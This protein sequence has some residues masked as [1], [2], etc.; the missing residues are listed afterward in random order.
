MPT[1]SSTDAPRETTGPA[2]RVRLVLAG[3]GHAQLSV[4][5]A[6]A[7]R[8]RADLDATLITPSPTAIYSGMVPG[9]MAGEH[10]LRAVQIDL[11]RLAERAGV[12]LIVD[13]VTALDANERVLCTAAGRR[14]AY[15][16]LSLDVGGAPEVRDF[17]PLGDRAMAVRPLERFVDQWH[18]FVT[19][20]S[21]RPKTD[22]VVVGGGAAGVELALAA[23]RALQARRTHATV[24]LVAAPDS[25][26]RGLARGAARRVDR[27]LERRG[28]LV[29]RG[30]ARGE[31]AAVRLDSG[32][33]IPADGV[34]IATG[35]VPPAWLNESGLELAATGGVAVGATQR[36]RSHANVFAA[37]D[38]C[39]RIDRPLARSGVHAVKA[40][41]VLARNLMAWPGE[42]RGAVYQPNRR[43]LM[44]LSTGGEQAI[45]SWGALSAEGRW[46]WRLKRTIDRRFIQQHSAFAADPRTP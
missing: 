43:T 38:V 4:L 32:L 24:T 19:T 13:A 12:R 26:L 9:W 28:I 41:P 2:R 18:R 30:I 25:W 34:I 8:P 45:G 40:G 29:Q 7:A 3:G 33:R 27:L 37:G 23:Q 15:D 44:L 20:A 1:F 31:Q 35:N 14:V 22:V 36:S 17:A 39:T 6:L 11:E 21:V 42:Q 5:Q 46:V 10:L 16:L